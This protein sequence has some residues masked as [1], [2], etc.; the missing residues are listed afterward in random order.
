[1]N[2]ESNKFEKLTISKETESS[3]VDMVTRAQS[4]PTRLVRP[5]GKPVPEHWSIFQHGEKVVA[6][7]YTF[8]ISHIGEGYMVLEPVGPVLIGDDGE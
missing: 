5:N 7:N 6:K 2:P 1:M 4:S 8:T 3:F